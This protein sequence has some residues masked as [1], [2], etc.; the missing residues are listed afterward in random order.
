MPI[1]HHFP[2]FCLDLE[3][4]L[5][6]EM[7]QSVAKLTGIEELGLTTQEIQ[8]YDELMRIRLSALKNYKITLPQIQEI[9]KDL[10]PLD[11]AREFLAELRKLGQVVII[12]DTFAEFLRPVL[13][14]LNNPMVFCNVLEVDDKGFIKRHIMRS[15][16]GKRGM[17]AALSSQGYSIGAA[18]DSYNDVGMLQE[19][20]WGAFLFA[21][22][23]ITEQFPQIP[24]LQSYGDL[25]SYWK[26][27]LY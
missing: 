16:I 13:R 25:L 23:H 10:Q 15:S 24:D 8:S 4:V 17:L 27:S 11:G 21:P 3:G 2:L 5:W 19:A 1:Q 6:P 22:K 20:H 12:S 14:E 18:G 7:W 9:I 26:H